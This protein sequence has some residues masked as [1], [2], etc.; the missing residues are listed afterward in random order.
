M[1]RCPAS[2]EVE[3]CMEQT[4]LPSRLVHRRS[5]SGVV[6]TAG[7]RYAVNVP[8]WGWRVDLLDPLHVFHRRRVL[9]IMAGAKI[10]S[11]DSLSRD[12]QWVGQ[13]EDGNTGGMI[14]E[15]CSRGRR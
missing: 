15:G 2:G 10:E 11:W 1:A 6:T 4:P 9:N 14:V 13:D 12:L 5:L 8:K 7:F 3:G